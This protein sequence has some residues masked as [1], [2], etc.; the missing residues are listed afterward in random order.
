MLVKRDGKVV[1]VIRDALKSTSE[2]IVFILVIVNGEKLNFA[3]LSVGNVFA[4]LGLQ[5]KG[6]TSDLLRRALI[7]QGSLL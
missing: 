7:C 5:E 2:E 4:K 6:R 1:I 3:I